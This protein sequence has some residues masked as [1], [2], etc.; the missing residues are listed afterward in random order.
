M[1]YDLWDVRMFPFCSITAGM[2]PNLLVTSA[3]VLYSNVLGVQTAPVPTRA[4][5][6]IVC[7]A[8]WIQTRDHPPHDRPQPPPLHVNQRIRHDV[9]AGEHS[10]HCGDE[11][12]SEQQQLSIPPTQIGVLHS[13]ISSCIYHILRQV[14]RPRYTHAHRGWH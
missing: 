10:P 3:S 4:P 8:V 7:R 14:S 12:M 5:S 11:F 9:F 1:N 13:S 2:L 6:S